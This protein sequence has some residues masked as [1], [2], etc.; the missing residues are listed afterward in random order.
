MGVIEHH[1]EGFALQR[2]L[3]LNGQR[4]RIQAQHLGWAGG[5]TEAAGGGH[6]QRVLGGAEGQLV[7]ALSNGGALHGGSG[8]SGGSLF[9]GKGR[10]GAKGQADGQRQG[11]RTEQGTRVHASVL[12]RGRGRILAR[13]AAGRSGQ[14]H[15][16]MTWE[17]WLARTS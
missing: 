11:G 12:V 15:G 3:R 2:D 4:I 7:Q 10:R 8:G 17:G 5:I 9:G 14:P 13:V 1:A 16:R 6:E